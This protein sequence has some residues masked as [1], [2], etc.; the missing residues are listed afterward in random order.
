MAPRTPKPSNGGSIGAQCIKGVDT[1]FPCQD[2]RIKQGTVKPNTTPAGDRL[3][4]KEE[5]HQVQAGVV[6]SID[7]PY[8]LEM[9]V[10]CLPLCY[11]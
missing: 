1:V 4:T 9:G 5:P 10:M 6:A 3:V 2:V 8:P 11:Q 7:T